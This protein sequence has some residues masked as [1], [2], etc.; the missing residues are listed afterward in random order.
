MD[1][2]VGD[3]VVCSSPEYMGTTGRIVHIER[4]GSDPCMKLKWYWGFYE[5]LR[6]IDMTG[7]PPI[8][9]GELY[10]TTTEKKLPANVTM[11][12]IRI[13]SKDVFDT[14]PQAGKGTQ[15]FFCRFVCSLSDK[16]LTEAKEEDL[17][18]EPNPRKRKAEDVDDAD[19]RVQK[20]VNKIREAMIPDFNKCNIDDKRFVIDALKTYAKSMKTFLDENKSGE[21]KITRVLLTNFIRSLPPASKNPKIRLRKPDSTAEDEKA[22]ASATATADKMDEGT[23]KNEAARKEARTRQGQ[24][25]AAGEPPWQRLKPVPLTSGV[26]GA[27]QPGQVGNDMTMTGVALNGGSSPTSLPV[28]AAGP[29][30]PGALLMPPSQAMA[31][32]VG[33]APAAQGNIAAA[34]VLAIKPNSPYPESQLIPNLGRAMSAAEAQQSFMTQPNVMGSTPPQTLESASSVSEPNLSSAVQQENTKAAM[35]TEPPV[36]TVLGNVEENEAAFDDQTLGELRADR[37][38]LQRLKAGGL[39]GS[40]MRGPD[41]SMSRAERSQVGSGFVNSLDASTD[42][43]SSPKIANQISKNEASDLQGKQ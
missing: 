38:A 23:E 7:K 29:S 28:F 41:R 30:V 42:E 37:T 26:Q 21:N 18:F 15:V 40:V 34:P 22:A 12:K 6:N 2:D 33:G 24:E 32:S 11:R 9:I 20:S 39:Q 43:N 25:K 3:Y 27:G 5:I 13:T 19:D 36:G 1:T 14:L 4:S 8:E 17:D 10:A 16:K 31:A 35:V